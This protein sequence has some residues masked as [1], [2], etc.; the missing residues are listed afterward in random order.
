MRSAK[1]GVHFMDVNR[2]SACGEFCDVHSWQ[3]GTR[4]RDGVKVLWCHS[5]QVW[6][7]FLKLEITFFIMNRIYNNFIC[8]TLSNLL[9]YEW[10]VSDTACEVVQKHFARAGV[11]NCRNL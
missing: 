2:L 11:R 1:Y 3:N 5:H 8:F 7:G 4:G 9:I 10:E 6:L